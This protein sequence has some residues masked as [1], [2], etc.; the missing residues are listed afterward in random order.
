M[1]ESFNTVRIKRWDEDIFYSNF[2]DP[3][4]LNNLL[5]YLTGSAEK[6]ASGVSLRRTD[7]PRTRPEAGVLVRKFS[8]LTPSAKLSGLTPGISYC[9]VESAV[10]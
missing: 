5:A 3:V 9:S 4:S 1:Q 6:E 2:Y 8:Q 10:S 7:A